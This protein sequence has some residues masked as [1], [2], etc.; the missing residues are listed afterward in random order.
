MIG[1]AVPA[2]VV[3]WGGSEYGCSI[4]VAVNNPAKQA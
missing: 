1:R 2:A 3:C 4:L